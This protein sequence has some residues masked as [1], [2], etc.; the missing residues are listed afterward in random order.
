VHLV[1]SS[2]TVDLKFQCALYLIVI[3][4][5]HTGKWLKRVRDLWKAVV[6]EEAEHWEGGR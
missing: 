1:S 2:G 5:T 6:S 4:K 3:Y